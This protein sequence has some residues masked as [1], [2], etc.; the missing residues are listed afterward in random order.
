MYLPRGDGCSWRVIGRRI[1]PFA[2][3]LAASA[4]GKSHSW[5]RETASVV[6]PSVPPELA[7]RRKK[8]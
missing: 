4:S 7:H 5:H 8:L 2:R 3:Q 1:L 6:R